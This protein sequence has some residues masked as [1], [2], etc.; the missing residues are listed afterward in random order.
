MSNPF[1][2]GK[3]T[4]NSRFS[5][6]RGVGTLTEESD[7]AFSVMQIFLLTDNEAPQDARYS[8]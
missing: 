7:E 5:G 2:D 8:R 6:A 1:V 3:S 4:G